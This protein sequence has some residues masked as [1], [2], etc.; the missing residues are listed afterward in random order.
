MREQLQHDFKRGE[1]LGSPVKRNERKEAMLDLVPFAGGWRIMS[2]GDRQLLFIGQ[3]LQL[4]LPEP[5]F[6]PIGTAAISRDQHLLV[7]G[8][9]GLATALPPPS[10]TLH[11]ELGGLMINA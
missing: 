9:E 4:L 8:I 1:G 7:I 2:D 3:V 6:H 11:R 5:V 10:E